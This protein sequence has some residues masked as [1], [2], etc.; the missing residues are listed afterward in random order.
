MLTALIDADG[1]AHKAAHVAPGDPGAA[2]GIAVSLVARTVAATGADRAVLAFS[3]PR[4]ACFRRT[5]VSASYKA[6]R[7][8]PT[9]AVVASLAGA[10]AGLRSAYPIVRELPTLE[11]D[12][13]I[14]LLATCPDVAGDRVVVADDGDLLQVPGRHYRPGHREWVR[15]T[16]GE[17]ERRFMSAVLSGCSGDGVPGLPG[18]GPVKAARI[19]AGV[20][21]EDA[22]A[23]VVAAY[24]ARGLA[25]ADAVVQARL[26]RV[27]RWGEY[28][29]AAGRVGLWEPALAGVC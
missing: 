5:D 20:A 29:V 19:L 4:A 6:G 26:V 11:A 2:A 12:D 9:P 24:E 13:V 17:A 14:G 22:W 23:A 10:F 16:A 21:P 28:D 15:V 7:P 3:C 27:L 18:V 25:E 1:P 8:D